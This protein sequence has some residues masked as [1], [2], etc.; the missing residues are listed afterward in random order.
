M[1]L[2]LNHFDSLSEKILLVSLVGTIN[3]LKNNAISIDEAEKF[4]FSPYMIKF[5]KDKKCNEDIVNIIE[6][7]C[8]L[9]DIISLIPDK[10]NNILENMNNKSI[11]LLKQYEEF[12]LDFWISER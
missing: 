7:G 11:D 5:L 6:L 3:S 10:F 9:E 4:L 1:K 12:N 2:L 8:E